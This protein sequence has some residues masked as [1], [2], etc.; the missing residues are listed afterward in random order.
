MIRALAYG[1]LTLFA[2][3]QNYKCMT[4]LYMFQQGGGE[5][6]AKHLLITLRSWIASVSGYASQAYILS[7]SC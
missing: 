4:V 2:F 6:H 1:G 7:L 5:K 3:F